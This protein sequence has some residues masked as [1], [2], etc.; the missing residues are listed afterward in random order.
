MCFKK[1]IWVSQSLSFLIHEFLNF[2]VQLQYLLIKSV[3]L[4]WSISILN[5]LKTFLLFLKPVVSQVVDLS[6][7]N[8][9]TL[10]RSHFLCTSGLQLETL[11]LLCLFVLIEFCFSTF[12][13]ASPNWLG[14]VIL[15]V[16]FCSRSSMTLSLR[17]LGWTAVYSTVRVGGPN[18]T[19]TLLVFHKKSF[20]PPS[21]F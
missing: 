6:I 9:L 17:L 13:F 21:S 4:A 1:N 5:E 12:L 18:V 14:V 16:G 3:E 7:Q 8:A 11:Q 10:W 20:T 15:L 2:V 19:A